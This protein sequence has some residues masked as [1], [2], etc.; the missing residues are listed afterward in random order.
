MTAAAAGGICCGLRVLFAARCCGS[1]LQGPSFLSELP[2]C[3]WAWPATSKVNCGDGCCRL[4][5]L[6]GLAGL[7]WHAV[8]VSLLLRWSY[9]VVLFC[10]CVA[11]PSVLVQVPPACAG[12]TYAYVGC[13]TC[14]VGTSNS[15]LKFG[16]PHIHIAMPLLVSYF[17]CCVQRVMILI[18]SYLA[19]S[20]VPP[21]SCRADHRPKAVAHTPPLLFCWQ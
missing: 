19:T 17:V 8:C 11:L 5:A 20:A 14:L 10:A 21:Q 2:G 7:T 6:H 12:A 16:Y 9:L 1:S 18:L 15:S 4:P 13:W 3:P